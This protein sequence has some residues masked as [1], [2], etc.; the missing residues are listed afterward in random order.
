MIVWHYYFVI[1]SHPQLYHAKVITEGG[2]FFVLKIASM[3]TY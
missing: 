2:L 1:K 3:D